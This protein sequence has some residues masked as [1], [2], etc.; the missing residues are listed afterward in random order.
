MEDGSS[1]IGHAN[2]QGSAG[3]VSAA[4]TLGALVLLGRD[5][6]GHRPWSTTQPG[7]PKNW[8][9]S[10]QVPRGGDPRGS[11]R[12]G[13]THTLGATGDHWNTEPVEPAV[14]RF[15]GLP[16]AGQLKEYFRSQA[17]QRTA[18]REKIA[19]SQGV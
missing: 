12:V 1:R 6:Q 7:H 11:C 15:R 10:F 4:R 3:C 14:L 13:I 16:K 5:Q 9:W 19:S 8:H 18:G 17:L 2:P